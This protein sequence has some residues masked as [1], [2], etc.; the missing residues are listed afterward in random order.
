MRPP[1]S[2]GTAAAVLWLRS[3]FLSRN[4]VHEIGCDSM[5]HSRIAIGAAK[6]FAGDGLPGAAANAI[7]KRRLPSGG[8]PVKF[9]VYVIELQ[10][11]E[12]NARLLLYVLRTG[13]FWR[14]EARNLGIQH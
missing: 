1:D 11:E 3:Q 5:R 6:S 13:V 2:A 4:G 12:R 10:P 7:A 14:R 8:F 9:N